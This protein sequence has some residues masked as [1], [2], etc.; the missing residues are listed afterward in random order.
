MMGK[1]PQEDQEQRESGGATQGRLLLASPQHG[2]SPSRSIQQGA[3]GSRVHLRQTSAG[4]ALS[5]TDL[6]PGEVSLCV[7]A[8]NVVGWC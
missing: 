4:L 5:R 1:V 3:R 6:G 2:V 7:V 8:R